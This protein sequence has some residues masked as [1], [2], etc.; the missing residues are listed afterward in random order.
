MPLQHVNGAILK[1]CNCKIIFSGDGKKIITLYLELDLYVT[2]SIESY[3]ESYF[4]EE[5]LQLQVEKSHHWNISKNASKTYMVVIFMLKPLCNT[6]ICKL[7]KWKFVICSIYPYDS[8]SVKKQAI[9]SLMKHTCGR[10][11]AD[12]KNVKRIPAKFSYEV[13][14]WHHS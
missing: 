3:F 12:S 10:K 9:K 2:N 5:N 11:F 1:H 6:H 8:N 4:F 7:K 13:L 14:E